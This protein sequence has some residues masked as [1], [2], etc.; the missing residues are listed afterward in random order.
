MHPGKINYA[1]QRGHSTLIDSH[2]SLSDMM[3]HHNGKYNVRHLHDVYNNPF[4]HEGYEIV[5]TKNIRAGEELMNSY[6]HCNI[7]S[8]IFDWFGTPGE[9]ICFALCV[10]YYTTLPTHYVLESYL[11]L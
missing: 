10:V 3:N 9:C 1:L 2:I 7:C 6:N 11:H 4:S 5:T 8:D